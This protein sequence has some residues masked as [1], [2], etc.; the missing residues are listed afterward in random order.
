MAS[1]IPQSN[2]RWV[3]QAL[4]VDEPL[5]NYFETYEKNAIMAKRADMLCFECPVR[6]RCLEFAISNQGTGMHG[7]VWLTLGKYAKNR[8]RH[9]TPEESYQLQKEIEEITEKLKKQAKD[10]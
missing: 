1:M 7:A 3:S 10:G 8:N 6:K 5:A 4:C 2:E 9:K